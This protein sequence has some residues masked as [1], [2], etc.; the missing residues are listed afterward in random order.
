MEYKIDDEKE[1]KKV[2][3]GKVMF[4]LNDKGWSKWKF[5]DSVLSRR[6]YKFKGFKE[7]VNVLFKD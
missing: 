4:V 7:W 3:F 2:F 1:I 5:E 6:K